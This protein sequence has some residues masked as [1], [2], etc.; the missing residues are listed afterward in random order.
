MR[1]ILPLILLLSAARATHGLAGQITYTYLGPN[2]Y[3]VTVTY[4]SDSAAAGVDRCFIDLE[5]WNVL[6]STKTFVGA[7]T[8][9]P[10]ANGPAGSGCSAPARI[11]V[12]LRPRVKRS[13]YVVD[14]TLPGPGLYE[15]R[16]T[17]FA[18]VENVRNMT[19]SGATSFYVETLLNNNPFIG[20]NRSPL[21]LNDPIDDACTGQIWTHNPG[22][23]DPDGDSLV[24]SLIP[25]QQYDPATMQNPIPVANYRF[26]DAFGGTFTIDRQTG[27]I[28]WNAPQQV[29]VYTISILIEEY[30]NGRRIGYVI[31]DMAIFVSPCQNRPPVIE[32]PAETCITAGQRLSFSVRAYDLDARD[33]IYFYLN[34]AGLGFNG[35]FQAQ[36]SPATI[37]PSAFPLTAVNPPSV[38]ALF[39]WQTVCNHIRANFYQIDWYA[40]DNLRYRP[41][42]AAHAVTKVYV[43]G[44]P[45]TGLT[46]TPGPRQ[47]T[48]SWQAPPC[49][50]D[51]Y[52]IYRSPA[53]QPY[54]D[55]PCCKAPLSGY[56][57]VATVPGS[58]TSYTDA[59]LEFS[60]RYCYRLRARYGATFSCPSE[61]ACIELPINF[62]LMLQDSV[63]TTDTQNGAIWVAWQDPLVLDT[64]F[65]PPPYR[66]ALERADGLTGTTF[67]TIATALTTNGYLDQGGLS[68]ATRPYRYRVRLFD[69]TGKEVASSNT[70]TSIFLTIQPRDGALLLRWEQN[71]P[72]IN[73]TFFIY[74]ADPPQPGNFI[75]IAALP[76]QA[77]G[78]QTFTY[79]DYG[80]QNDQTYCYYILSR[81]SYG[82]SGVRSPLWNASNIAC[83]MPRDTTPPC[84]P[85]PSTYVVESDCENYLIDIRWGAPDSSCGGDV[86]SYGVYF[87]EQEGGPYR[88]LQYVQE[89]QRRFQWR[90]PGTLKL[91]IALTARDTSGNESSLGT[92]ICFDNCPVFMLPNTFT[93][94]GDGVNDVFRPFI[95][96]NIRSVRCWIYDRWGKLIHESRDIDKL[97]DGSYQGRQAPE[98]TYFYV[99][100]VEPDTREKRSFRKAGSITLLR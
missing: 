50:P 28:T 15:L 75:Q 71:V 87:S 100:E 62:P 26:P 25:C 44:P 95:Y 61:E 57:L 2:R 64:T 30:R 32:A 58:I 23:Y 83:E 86:G 13:D 59:D 78:R 7:Y 51:A 11:G 96:R 77:T 79:I 99:V 20:T 35:P 88:F 46:L 4:Y 45:P 22:A 41:P 74:R 43:I 63:H 65:F 49:P 89:P 39:S 16:F 68:T 92:P 56:V 76:V 1:R 36:P 93:P 48:L 42:L 33:S 5:V 53:P 97:W 19:N 72:W 60:P 6:G 66:Y 82:V 47:V 98:G 29:G 81:G 38:S 52:E 80:L 90:A 54:T 70:A 27:L 18:R 91:C 24:Y 10:R 84:L 31:R 69:G 3:R 85:E 67:Q 9:I 21:L 8:N 73:D 55:T 94:N 34:N 12:T 37:S 14:I 40:H 17:D